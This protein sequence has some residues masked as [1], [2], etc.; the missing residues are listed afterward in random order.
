LVLKKL[1]V[2]IAILLELPEDYF[3]VK[4]EYEKASDDY[5]CYVRHCKK[6]S[7]SFKVD[8]LLTFAENLPSSYGARMGDHQRQV[9]PWPY[10][11]FGLVGAVTKTDK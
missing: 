1:L 2:L 10:V 3:V 11:V 5:L 9:S 8:E 7:L 4:H 6:M